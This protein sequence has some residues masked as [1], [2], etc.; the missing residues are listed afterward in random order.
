MKIATASSSGK[1]TAGDP[2]GEGLPLHQFHDEKRLAVRDLE[3]IKRCDVRVIERCEQL[4][5]A[6]RIDRAALG[7]AKIPRATTMWY[8][9]K[10]TS[11]T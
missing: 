7:R 2:L 1:A 11:R 4:G 5:L 3:S 6:L 8:K 10:R 9:S